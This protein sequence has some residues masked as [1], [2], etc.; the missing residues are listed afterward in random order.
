MALAVIASFTLTMLI[1]ATAMWG[2]TRS[3]HFVPLKV[4]M[5]T[6]FPTTFFV[7]STA[8][9]YLED[10]NIGRSLVASLFNTGFVG[11]LIDRRSIFDC[12]FCIA[13][14]PPCT[15]PPPAVA[16]DRE[17]CFAHPDGSRVG[18]PRGLITGSGTFWI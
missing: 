11:L 14:I 17:N 15:L 10:G 5:W 3:G 7:S 2:F 18:E 12:C 6:L 16:L 1:G 4:L 8:L 13:E 9:E